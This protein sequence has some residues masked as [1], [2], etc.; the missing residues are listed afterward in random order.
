MR[1]ETAFFLVTALAVA[2]LSCD[3]P[4]DGPARLDPVSD[5]VSDEQCWGEDDRYD[6]CDYVCAGDVTYCR[7]ACETSADCVGRGLPDDYVYCN[8]PREGEGF[9]FN[10]DYDYDYDA[11]V[12]DPGPVDDPPGGG[13]D[14]YSSCVDS[15]LEAGGTSCGADCADIC[16]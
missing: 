3:E 8:H 7:V 12:A 6:R 14:C 1:A 16:D 2:A 11:C 5:C 15:C 9:C 4:E 10:Y 13:S